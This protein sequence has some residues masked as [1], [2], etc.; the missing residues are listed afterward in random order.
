MNNTRSVTD[1][2]QAGLFC[3]YG[4]NMKKVN[5]L[6]TEYTIEEK[7][8]EECDG[9]CDHST[10]EIKITEKTGDIGDFPRYQRKV[11]RHELIHAF[12]FESGLCQEF[13]HD[14]VTIDW[15]AQQFPKLVAAFKEAG[16]LE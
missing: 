15:M 1:W 12:L 2:W 6:G 9:Y 16:C 13:G 10:K 7:K 11:M 4:G 14:E 8:L 5:V 3:F